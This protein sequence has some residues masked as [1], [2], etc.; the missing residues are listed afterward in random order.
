MKNA[1]VIV[2][3]FMMI[4]A[5]KCNSDQDKGTTEDTTLVI[6]DTLLVYEVNTETKTLKKFT[7]VPD[8]AFTAQRVINGLNEKYSNVQ[9]QFIKQSNDTLYVSVPDN[10][11]L[12]ER[13]GSTGASSWFQDAILNL[14]GIQGVN[15]VNIDMEKR[16]HAMPGIFTKENILKQYKEANDT[17]PV[18]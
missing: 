2:I 4:T 15:Y 17:I 16:S 9:L 11:F 3:C 7:E 6:P 13:M 5:C 18:S 10:E 12:G 1:I 14:T 8:S